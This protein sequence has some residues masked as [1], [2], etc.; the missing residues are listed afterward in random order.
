MV[1]FIIPHTHYPQYIHERRNDARFLNSDYSLTYTYN[2]NY[3]HNHNDV[4][5]T[6]VTLLQ[7]RER[8]GGRNIMCT[9]T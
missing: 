6:I 4:M 1:H 9:D 2:T 5:I 7:G 3:R 8:E